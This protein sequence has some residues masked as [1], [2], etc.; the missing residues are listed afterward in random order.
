MQ[1]DFLLNNKVE[2][3]EFLMNIK[4][5]KHEIFDENILSVIN[6]MIMLIRRSL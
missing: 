5:F 6:S 3:E 4:I 1:K 2:L